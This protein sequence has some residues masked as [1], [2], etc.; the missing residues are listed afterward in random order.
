MA[1]FAHVA[2]FQN[3]RLQRGKTNMVISTCWMLEQGKGFVAAAR[4]MP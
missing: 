2:R 4:G 1:G 3:Q